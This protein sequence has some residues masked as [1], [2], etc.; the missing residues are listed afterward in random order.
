MTQQQQQQQQQRKEIGVMLLGDGL[1]DLH[2]CTLWD[3][4]RNEV[5]FSQVDQSYRFLEP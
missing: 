4:A 2:C 5:I 1:D 3:S